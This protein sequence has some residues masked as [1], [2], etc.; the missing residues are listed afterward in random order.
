MHK[1][2]WD[3]SSNKE[4]FDYYKKESQS[5]A[6]RRRFI[7]IR[8]AVLRNAKMDENR[9][10]ILDIADIGCGA[11]TQCLLWA[12]LGHRVYGI[13]INQPLIELARERSLAAGQSISY[14]V[15]SALNLPWPDASMDVCL[16]LELLEH[17]DDWKSCLKECARVLRPGGIL[18]LTTTNKLC[19]IQ[20][21]FK[22][23]LYSWYPAIL[24]RHFERLAVTSRPDLVMYAKYPAVNWFTFYELRTQLA[25]FGIECKDRFDIVDLSQKSTITRL[26]VS[27]IRALSVLRF[28][29]HV[30][31]PGTI[32]MGLKQT[33]TTA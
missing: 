4:F 25:T 17:V 12:E 3:H 8:N 28:L 30:A 16:I 14:E 32:L 19:P 27:A 7:S 18:F 22:V 2:K 33:S 10:A 20:Q 31:T 9:S 23:P 11:G 1:S 24:K 29:G 6:T 15:G 13:D 5:E 21:E 26:L